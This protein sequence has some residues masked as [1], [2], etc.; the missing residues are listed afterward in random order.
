M[1]LSLEKESRTKLKTIFFP[2]IKQRTKRNFIVC[3]E[4]LLIHEDSTVRSI[5]DI[6]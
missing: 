3:C 6:V 1:I 2:K 5:I 4:E